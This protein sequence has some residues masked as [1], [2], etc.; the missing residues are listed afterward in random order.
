M[1][2][3]IF[4][5]TSRLY[6]VHRAGL[7]LVLTTSSRNFTEIT[8]GM[9]VRHRFQFLNISCEE[10]EYTGENWDIVEGVG[11]TGE[12]GMGS[13]GSNFSVR[14]ELTLVAENESDGSGSWVEEGEFLK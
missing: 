13:N 5:A 8:R 12:R 7:D 6:T 4:L 10:R 3:H 11:F 14:Y 1:F 9:K 2:N